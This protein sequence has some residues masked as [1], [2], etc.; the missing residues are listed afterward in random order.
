MSVPVALFV[1][2]GL[3]RHKCSVQKTTDE[4]KA[5]T[6]I[7]PRPAL[8]NGLECNG[9]LQ[10]LGSILFGS[11]RRTGMT[12]TF[13]LAIARYS[14]VLRRACRMSASATIA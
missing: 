11:Q 9:V 4:N 6:L 7:D 1:S 3:M 5:I 10:Q 13:S 2:Q 12:A 8:T 14:C